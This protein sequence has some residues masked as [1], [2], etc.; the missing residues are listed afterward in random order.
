MNK[1]VKL[2]GML[3]ILWGLVNLCIFVL[4]KNAFGTLF[5]ISINIGGFSIDTFILAILLCITGYNLFMFNPFG[6][7][8]GLVILWEHFIFAG[9]AL[10]IGF[11]NYY[12]STNGFTSSILY[13]SGFDIRFLTIAT[14]LT[15]ILLVQILALSSMAGKKLFHKE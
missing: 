7:I 3:F 10:I 5:L 12:K 1:I 6:R 9:L 14:L 4:H 8:M 2:S 11:I 13:N 15:V